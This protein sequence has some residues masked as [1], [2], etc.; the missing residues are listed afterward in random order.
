VSKN[1]AVGACSLATT[2]D[3]LVRKILPALAIFLAAMLATSA[4]Q[5]AT[6]TARD[7]KLTAAF[8]GGRSTFRVGEV[9]PLDLSFTST[10]PGK[11][12]FD[13]ATY[14]RSGRL[15]SETFA[16]EPKSGWDDPLELYF[17]SY[18]CFMG[19]GLRGIDTLTD[20]PAVVHLELN[21]WVRFKEPGRYRITITSSRVSKNGAPLF[22]G[23]GVT[24]NQLTLTIVSP[25]EAWQNS[26]LNA[27]I[28]VLDT[29]APTAPVRLDQ[30]NQRQEAAKTLRYLGTPAAARAMARRLTGS[31]WDWDFKLGLAGSPAKD[32]GLQEM[33]TLLVDPKFPVVDLFLDAMSVIAVSDDAGE[34]R[35]TQKKKAEERFRQELALAVGDKEGKARAVSANTVVEDSAAGSDTLPKAVKRNLTREL[36]AGF[37]DLPI[38]KQVEL[39]QYR[40]S[41]LDHEEM[42]PLLRTLAQQ[43]HD[44]SELR[45]MKAYQSNNLSASALQ[46]W[47]EM[48]P[49]EARPIVLQEI[50]RPKPRFSANVLGMLPEKDLPEIDSILAEHLNPRQ[51]YEINANLASLIARYATPAV[52]ARVTNF[53]DPIL[54]KEACAV[55]DPLLA[56]ILKVDPEGARPRIETAMSARGEDFSACNHMLLTEVAQLQNDP[57]LQEIAIKSL[58]DSDPQI[59]AGAAAYLKDYGSASAE[60]ALWSRFTAWSE[61]WK[62]QENEF[63]EVAGQRSD[64]QFEPM[65]GSN[66]MRALAAGQGWLADEAKLR[67]LV[68]LSIGPDQRRE[69][70]E[71]LRVWK[72]RPWSILFIAAGKGQFEIAQYR[73]RSLQAAKDKLAQFPRGS[74]FDWTDVGQDEGEQ[75][76]FQEISRFTSERGF[77]L[78]AGQK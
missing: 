14:D 51:N 1:T 53:L 65:A 78:L 35:H 8:H 13:N 73:A 36:I 61:R 32:A 44:F 45:E 3:A 55:Q 69:A 41:A 70:E 56:Y 5:T 71:N 58:D 63:Q 22:Q 7:V 17:R 15:N 57:L 31:E 25:T 75:K 40:W 74:T 34:D 52:E 76:A 23:V 12:Q 68:D 77:T 46:H 49:E 26:T 19:G 47:Y 6:G 27:A 9:I 64:R 11:Y 38:D 39:V 28:A 16:I 18:A 4:A 54:A 21:E 42:L 50:A 48:A 72:K 2:E 67:R 60:D 29:P 24:S 20:K 59:V 66:L 62:G 37:D 43:Y 10:A 30:L 33:E